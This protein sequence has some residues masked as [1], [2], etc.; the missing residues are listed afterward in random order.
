MGFFIYFVHRLS[1]PVGTPSLS[2][3][4]KIQLTYLTLGVDFCVYGPFFVSHHKGYHTPTSGSCRE[5]FEK[6]RLKI[7]GGRKKK[8]ILKNKKR[9]WQERGTPNYLR[10]ANLI[11]PVVPKTGGAFNFNPQYPKSS[12]GFWFC[13]NTLLLNFYFF[14]PLLIVG[15]SLT[16]WFLIPLSF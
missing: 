6:D 14:S 13:L 2:M 12:S 8:R 10:T 9:V 5:I 4:V 16:C 3:Q 7:T 15:N 11:A 1:T